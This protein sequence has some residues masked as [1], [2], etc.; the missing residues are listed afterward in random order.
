MSP[1]N[2]FFLPR[3]NELMLL[4]PLPGR[5]EGRGGGVGCI[6]Q[7]YYITASQSAA[8]WH[9]LSQRQSVT[10]FNMCEPAQEGE[11][12]ARSKG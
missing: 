3:T 1:S 11:G 10:E 8:L 2:F 12:D 6:H 4:G 7:V 5:G 9:E